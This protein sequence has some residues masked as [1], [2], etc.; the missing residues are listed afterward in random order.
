MKLLILTTLA[1]AT[2]S[3]M[4]Q[5]HRHAYRHNRR[6]DV[7]K[8]GVYVSGPVETVTVYVLNG[9]PISEGEVNQGIANGTLMWGDDGNLSTSITS[10]PTQLPIMTS[11]PPPA[12]TAPPPSS[13]AP[14]PPESSHPPAA[15]YPPPAQNTNPPTIPTEAPVPSPSGSSAKADINKPFPNGQLPCDQ[16][17]DGYGAT[18]VD[19]AGLGGWIGIQD[20]GFSSAAGF[21]DIMTVPHGSCPDGT[22]CKAGAFCS[23]SCPDGYLKSS[24]P[25]KQGIKKQSVGGLFCNNDGKLE[26]AS[27]AIANTL[28]V[29]GTDKV[30][31]MVENRL[32][33]PQSI[34]QTDYPGMLQHANTLE[35]Q[36]LIRSR[37]GV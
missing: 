30:T 22:C 5:P 18:L 2:M 1:A 10:A 37:H 29:K 23:Y 7:V 25:E 8:R 12:Q 4:A 17:P 21:D 26:L 6:H 24:W 11:Q 15:N 36:V 35:Y 31:I 20:P 3:V 27:G 16:F 9:N 34:C 19:H 33:V 14:P 13:Q 28:C 32:S